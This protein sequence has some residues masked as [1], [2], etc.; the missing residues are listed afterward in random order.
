MGKT[1]EM[2]YCPCGGKLANVKCKCGCLACRRTLGSCDTM[3]NSGKV[4]KNCK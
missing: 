2:K 1:V 3:T 4:C